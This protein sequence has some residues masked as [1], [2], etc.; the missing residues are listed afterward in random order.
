M[1]LKGGE[2]VGKNKFLKK[3][4]KKKKKS[5]W[6]QSSCDLDRQ[7]ANSCW[8]WNDHKRSKIMREISK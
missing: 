1:K 2:G 4:G 5:I 7:H 8:Q 3:K 6:P